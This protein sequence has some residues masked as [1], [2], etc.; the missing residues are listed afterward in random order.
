MTNAEAG[1]PFSVA[2]FGIGGVRRIV[3]TGTVPAD[4]KL[5]RIAT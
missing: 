2:K 1:L 3:A 4:R 5:R